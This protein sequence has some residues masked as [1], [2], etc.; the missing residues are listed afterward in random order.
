MKNKVLLAVVALLIIASCRKANNIMGTEDGSNVPTNSANKSHAVP[1]KGT[2]TYML[3]NTLNLPCNCG[4]SFAVGDFDGS[5]NVTHMGLLKSKNKT[6]AS[7]IMVG[8]TQIGNHITVQCGSFIAANGDE[9]YVNISPYDLLFGNT[10]AVGS[11][12]AE[13]TGGTGRFV[14]AT[15]SFTGTIT[16]NYATPNIITLTNI[17]GSIDY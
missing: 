14:N 8:P 10:S 3:N 9:I 11:L 12:S 15:G 1:F 5:G 7:P 6:C 2:M 17:N 13:F 16:L 4:T